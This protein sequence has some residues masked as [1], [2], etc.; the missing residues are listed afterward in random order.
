MKDITHI[1]LVDDDEDDFIIT[2]DLLEEI[3]NGQYALEWRSDFSG[4]LQTMRKNG[5]DVYLVDYRLADRNGIELMQEAKQLG[6][7]GPIIFLTGQGDKSVDLEAMQAGAADYL[8]KA[9][10]NAPGLERAIRYTVQRTQMNQ[11]LGHAER[12]KT[13]QELAGAVCHE[14]AQP[15]QIMSLSL[16]LMKDKPTDPS[17]IETCDKMLK[18][19]TELVHKLRN[20][21]DV[22]NQPYLDQ[23]IIDIHASS[24]T[25]SNV[26]Q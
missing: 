3:S 17:H 25:T 5:H 6:C 16:M 22:K 14:F 24:E 26:R 4:A 23:H 18:R 19:I 7:E 13:A 21:T 9:Q 1:L 10:I 2:R 12:L 8:D 11:A 15:L 20:I